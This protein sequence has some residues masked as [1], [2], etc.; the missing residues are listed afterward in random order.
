MAA[1]SNTLNSSEELVH[2]DALSLERAN[3]EG[4]L[5]EQAK[6]GTVVAGYTV[7][8]KSMIGAGTSHS[9]LDQNA[10]F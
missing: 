5:V 8:T 6:T 1:V 10:F 4:K 3:T 9:R 7:I 2:K